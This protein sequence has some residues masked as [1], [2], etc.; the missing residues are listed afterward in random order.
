[1]PIRGP[2]CRRASISPRSSASAATR[3]GRWSSATLTSPALTSRR[4]WTGSSV[5]M[6]VGRPPACWFRMSGALGEI[7]VCPPRARP[8]GRVRGGGLA[9]DQTRFLK[10]QLSLPVSM[11][12]QWWVSRSSSAVVILASPNTLRHSPKVRL[13]VTITEVRRPRTASRSSS[14]A[15][16]AACTI[17]A[18]GFTTRNRWVGHARDALARV[19][20]RHLRR[21]QGVGDGDVEIRPDEGKIVV[22]AVPDDYLGFHLR[23]GDDRGVVDAG[24]DDI[25]GSD[26]GSYSS[27]SSA[28]ARSRSSIVAKR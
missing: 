5:A 21:P 12:S 4:P 6:M 9:R 13:V 7:P 15:G 2:V 3:P 26:M 8:G 17:G 27:R 24:V 25:T 1:M 11:N 18:P 19:M 22:A 10:R 16:D 23:G 28:P 20:R 14:V